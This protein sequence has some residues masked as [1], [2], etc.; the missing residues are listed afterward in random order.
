MLTITN[1]SFKDGVLQNFMYMLEKL[2]KL[3]ISAVFDSLLNANCTFP[4]KIFS[5]HKLQK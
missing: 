2:L 1:T 5:L 4:I 3:R